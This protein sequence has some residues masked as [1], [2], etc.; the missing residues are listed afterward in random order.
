MR[1]ARFIL[2]AIL[3]LVMVT[4]RASAQALPQVQANN[5]SV[6]F[7]GDAADQMTVE[8]TFPT[9]QV[10][11]GVNDADYAVLVPKIAKVF[12]AGA[13]YGGT[14]MRHTLPLGWKPGGNDHVVVV[15][16]PWRTSPYTIP[17]IYAK[18]DLE[19]IL[20]DPNAPTEVIAAKLQAYRAARA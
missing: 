2:M 17:V 20:Q 5:G 6:K 10:E 16:P 13:M 15:V 1:T 18:K 4:H 9:L 14:G 7:A 12:N 19:E 3:L 11:L 8:M